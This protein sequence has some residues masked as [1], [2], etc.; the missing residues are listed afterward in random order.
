MQK[1]GTRKMENQTTEKNVVEEAI[2]FTSSFN[3]YA[4]F[5]NSYACFDKVYF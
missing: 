5:T 2:L 4:S 1:K 3:E